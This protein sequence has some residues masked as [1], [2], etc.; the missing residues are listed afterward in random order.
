MKPDKDKPQEQPSHNDRH[1]G[2]EGQTQNDNTTAQEE[3]TSWI[4][5]DELQKNALKGDEIYEKGNP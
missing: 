1:N 2:E 4:E 5:E 3:D